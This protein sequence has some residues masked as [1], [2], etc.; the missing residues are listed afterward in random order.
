MLEEKDESWS[1]TT[2]KEQT[3]IQAIENGPFI[4]KGTV[5]IIDKD[6]NEKVKSPKFGLCRCGA[7]GNQPF[8][9]GSHKNVAHS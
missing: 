7:S 3:T 6:G 4:V 9:D 2:K 5:T 8:C 1:E